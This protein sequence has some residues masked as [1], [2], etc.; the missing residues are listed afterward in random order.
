VLAAAVLP[1]DS[2]VFWTHAIFTTSR[3]GDLASLGNQSL[4]GM[5]LR[6]P[7]AAT[8]RDTALLLLVSVAVTAALYRARVLYRQDRTV[9][10]AITCGCAALAASPVSWTHHQ[11]WTV[12]AGLALF[13]RGKTQ[14]TFALGIVI[15]MSVR[16]PPPADDALT[17]FLAD[18]ARALAALGICCLG[19]VSAWRAARTQRLVL[20][21]R[22]SVRP[23]A[24][25][26][27]GAIGLV[28]SGMIVIT[29]L[30]RVS[31]PTITTQ[32]M[33][34]QIWGWSTDTYGRRKASIPEATPDG[35]NYGTMLLPNGKTRVAGAAGTDVARLVLTTTLNGP[36]YTVPLTSDLTAGIRVFVFD[37]DYYAESTLDTYTADGKLGCRCGDKLSSG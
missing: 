32:A 7:V 2:L 21:G 4:N 9:E 19:L 30:I 22:F 37:I 8:A 1:H 23:R 29:H 18:N 33:A 3:I 14:R 27:V 25:A 28:I 36:A 26:V 34:E 10:A 20:F 31:F 11:V 15:V 13:T 17:G 6:L 5:L 12:L 35:I 16:L 24:M